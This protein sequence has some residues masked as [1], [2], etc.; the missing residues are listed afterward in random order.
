[1]QK[2][3]NDAPLVGGCPICSRRISGAS[4]LQMRSV[5]TTTSIQ[6]SRVCCRA[7]R[8]GVPSEQRRSKL[9]GNFIVGSVVNAVPAYE[10]IIS[11]MHKF[12]RER[13]DSP[14]IWDMDEHN[15]IYVCMGPPSAHKIEKL[16]REEGQPKQSPA[17]V[18]TGVCDNRAIQATSLLS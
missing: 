1:M 12:R 16:V 3:S 9:R 2:S 4:M 18:D 6:H 13:I 14:L 15:D 8:W 11:V 10:C 17:P 7:G 5:Q